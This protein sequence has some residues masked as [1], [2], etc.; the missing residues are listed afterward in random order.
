MQIRR[1][2][3]I[4]NLVTASVSIALFTFSKISFGKWL[5]ADFKHRSIEKTLQELFPDKVIKKSRK[6]KLKLPKT[7]E[8]GNV[9]PI[10][11]TSTIDNIESVYILSEKNPV[12]LVAKFTLDPSLEPYI[13]ARF[14]MQETCDVIVIVKAGEE[15]FQARQKVKVTIGGCGG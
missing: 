5:L 3:F 1:R 13:G 9:V 6:I 11:I 8:N 10:T 14:K 12:P 7:A 15:Y 2:Q 4:K